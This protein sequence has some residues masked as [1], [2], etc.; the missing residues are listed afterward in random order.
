MWVHYISGT[1]RGRFKAKQQ[2]ID[3]HI[4]DYAG[5]V[6]YILT[7][8]DGETILFW[9]KYYGVFP[10]TIPSTQYSWSHGTLLS[11]PTMDV[12]FKFSFKEDFNVDALVEFNKNAHVSD[13]IKKGSLPYINT[14]NKT[15]GNVGN[16]WTGAPFI[17]TYYEDGLTFFKL[18]FRKPTGD[19]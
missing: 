12:T 5:A 9:S 4:M 16:T 7:A 3:D 11:N 14:Y 8:E 17:E 15:L 13:V 19:E 2:T 10:S 18:R 6:Y 1:F